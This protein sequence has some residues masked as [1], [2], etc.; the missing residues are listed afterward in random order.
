MLGAASFFVRSRRRQQCGEECRL[1]A[2]AHIPFATAGTL[3]SAKGVKIL[4]FFSSE[5]NRSKSLI[6]FAW[7]EKGQSL[8]PRH[9]PLNEWRWV[10]SPL[11]RTPQ[12]SVPEKEE[13]ARRE[14]RRSSRCN[15]TSVRLRDMG[16]QG[17]SFG[18]PQGRH[19]LEAA[20]PRAKPPRLAPV[21]GSR[22]RANAVT[23]YF[24]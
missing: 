20:A 10:T 2:L 5:K 1:G 11:G 8:A 14:P 23:Y 16:V 24:P 12:T 9:R 22:Y 4:R 17:I 7:R 15:R 19:W 6:T 21:P 3:R 13:A 18:V